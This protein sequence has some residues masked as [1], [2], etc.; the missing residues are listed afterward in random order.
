MGTPG[1]KEG[2]EF[3]VEGSQGWDG[4]AEDGDC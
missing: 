4:G 1:G 2:D 3:F